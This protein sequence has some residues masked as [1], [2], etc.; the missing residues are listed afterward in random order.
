MEQ[1]PWP[2]SWH[3]P[4]RKTK[5]YNAPMAPLVL[6]PLEPLAVLGA[7]TAFP[8]VEYDN[9]AVLRWVAESSGAT[10]RSAEHLAFTAAGVTRT[11][12]LERR[13]WATRPGEA[14]LGGLDTPALAA[15]AARRALHEAGLAASEIAAL[16]VATSTPHRMT[17]TVSAAVGAALGLVG[18]CQDIRAGCAGGLFALAQGALLAAAAGAPVLVLGVERFSGVIPPGNTN[19]ALA[20]GDGAA[21]VVLAPASWNTR[22][23]PAA[24]PCPPL[25]L[26]AAWLTSDGRLA[27]LVSTTGPLPPTAAALEA[28][29]YTLGGDP[30]ALAAALPERYAEAIDGALAR[31]GLAV[32][33]VDL[34]LPHQTSRPLMESVAGRAGIPFERTWAEGVARHANIGAAGAL[35]AFVEACAADRLTPGT[36]SLLA[37]VGGGMSWAAL[38][39]EC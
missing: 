4:I 29:G 14:E 23:S 12:G 39:L 27:G 16:L 37:A 11:L 2:A 17:G 34:F 32:G 36:R 35:T 24:R 7:A 30:E 1:G 18:A 33:S 3:A 6:G 19:A 25:T 15:V 5:C 28:S 26:R 8:P 9:A 10:P 13:A 38:V 20:L 31:A 22:P 21:A